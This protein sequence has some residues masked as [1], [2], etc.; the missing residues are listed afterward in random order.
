VQSRPTVEQE[1]ESDRATCKADRRDCPPPHARIRLINP[2]NDR[3]NQQGDRPQQ[4][5]D[6][7]CGDRGFVG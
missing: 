1:S 2:V 6:G 4:R 5:S 7:D 3:H